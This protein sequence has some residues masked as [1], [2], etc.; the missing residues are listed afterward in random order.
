MDE[1]ISR[2]ATIDA[3]QKIYCPQCNNYNGAMCRACEHMDDMDII[4]DMPAADVQ[5]PVNQWIKEAK[6]LL[7]AAVEDI[8]Q[9]KCDTCT[10]EINCKICCCE[11][12]YKWQHEAEALA[13]IREDGAE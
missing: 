9:D 4:D 1:Y 12:L 6:R 13:L 2:K 5:P 10:Q 3:I 8:Y 7:K 11:G